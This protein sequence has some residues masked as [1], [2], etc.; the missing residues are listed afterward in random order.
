[1]AAYRDTLE[2]TERRYM[3]GDVAELDLARSRTEVAT[4]EAQALALDRRRANYEHALAVLLGEVPSGFALAEIDWSGS[5][6]RIPPGVPSTVLARRPDVAAAQKAMLAA[7]ARLG[8]AQLA[9][10]PD[11]SLT[12][13][14]GFAST[15]LGDLFKRSSKAWGIGALASLPLF[16]GGRRTAGVARANAEWDEVAADYREQVLVAFKE[17]EDRLSELRLLSEQAGAQSRAVES[18]TRATTLSASRYRNGYVSQLELL[19]A[20]RS[21]LSNRRQALEVRSAQYQATVGLIVALGGGWDTTTENST[22]GTIGGSNRV[23]ATAGR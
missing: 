23:T 14:G 4:T 2:L 16:D 1:V 18:A 17:V 8:V 13:G 22:T 11:F 6:P 15:D 12:A 5:P 21:E 7:E 19:D 3:A 20:R 10:L 9:W